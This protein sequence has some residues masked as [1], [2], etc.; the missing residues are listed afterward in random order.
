MKQIE[1]HK[2]I[3]TDYNNKCGALE[4]SLKM[5]A[6]ML[7]EREKDLRDKESIVRQ[8]TDSVKQEQGAEIQSLEKAI[9]GFR[10]VTN[11]WQEQTEGEIIHLTEN[12][13][14]EL[15]IAEG[16]IQRILTKQYSANDEKLNELSTLKSKSEELDLQLETARKHQYVD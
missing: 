8:K 10:I 3:L 6:A 2:Q 9:E 4:I 15:L 5:E 13:R 12:N 1:Y 11:K 7:K 14:K 16:K